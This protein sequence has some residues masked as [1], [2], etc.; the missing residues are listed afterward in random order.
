MDGQGFRG[1][2]F[3]YMGHL[4]RHVPPDQVLALGARLAGLG[5]H[6]QIHLDP[7]LFPDLAPTLLR[8]PV[9]VVID[10]MG[11]IPADPGQR[12]PGFAH[13]R[14]MLDTGRAWVKVSGID[15]ASL[16]GPP[17]A[18]ALPMAR[19]LVA[20]Y[21][22]QVLWGTDWPHPNHAGPVPDDVLLVDLLAGIAPT[23]AARQALLVDN[24]QRLYRFTGPDAPA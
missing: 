19:R 23:P 6:L 9:P 3:N 13:L 5:W 4:G 12:H 18:D 21:P 14:R 20:D 24:P 16:Q 2:R 1:V 11:R 22:D 17:Y 7:S 8:S 15:R 10:H